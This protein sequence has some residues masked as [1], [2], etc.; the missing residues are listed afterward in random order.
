MADSYFVFIP[1]IESAMITPNPVDVEKNIKIQAYVI[2]EQK[3]LF[4]YFYY[5][6]E[7]FSGEV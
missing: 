5:S 1:K 3:E 6:D 4:P 2:E 7:I